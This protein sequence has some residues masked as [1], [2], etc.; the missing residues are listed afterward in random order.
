MESEKRKRSEDNRKFA[1][2][3]IKATERPFNFYKR[4]EKV[5]KASEERAELPDDVP[6]NAPFRAN[7]IP[8]KVLVPLYQAILDKDDERNK[9]VKRNAEVSLKL[10]QLPPRMEKSKVEAVQKKKDLEY[11]YEH[12]T[13]SFKPKVGAAVP[14][15][16]K[17]HKDFAA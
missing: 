6:Q 16:K 14:D 13:P 8:W 12:L 4:D 11:K 17:L 10:S 15:F 5:R 1:M 9:R 3:K 2:A 7:K